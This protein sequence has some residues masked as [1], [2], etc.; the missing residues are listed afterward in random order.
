MASGGAMESS[1][2]SASPSSSPPSTP[3]DP[4]DEAAPRLKNAWS[5]IVRGSSTP[6]RSKAEPSPCNPQP[7]EQNERLHPHL[8]SPDTPSRVSDSTIKENP[9]SDATAAVVKASPISSSDGFC[10]PRAEKNQVAC[11]VPS[12]MPIASPDK[13]ISESA[14]LESKPTQQSPLKSPKPAWG[15]LASNA[16]SKP[17]PE[18]VMGAVAWPAL[19]EARNTKASEPSKAVATQKAVSK[20]SPLSGD[21]HQLQAPPLLNREVGGTHQKMSTMMN[22]KSFTQV[23]VNGNNLPEPILTDTAFSSKGVHA[24]DADQLKRSGGKEARAAAAASEVHHR[25]NAASQVSSHDSTRSLMWDQGRGNHSFPAYGRGYANARESNVPAHHQRGGHRNLPQPF[26]PFVTPN[27]G[28]VHPGGFQNVPGSMY[29]IPAPSSEPILGATYFVPPAVQGVLMHG[30]DPITL[31]GLVVKQIEYYFSVENLCRDIY[32]RSKMDERGFVPVSVI[33][34]FNRVRMITQN[35]F[36]IIEALRMSNVVEGQGDKVRKKGDWANWL[37]P[38][39]L[40]SAG[41]SSP[42]GE[43][44]QINKFSRSSQKAEGADYQSNG[45]G[46]SKVASQ[47]KAKKSESHV[48]S[49]MNVQSVVEDPPQHE[50]CSC[51]DGRVGD[52]SVDEVVESKHF[53]QSCSVES[54]GSIE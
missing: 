14:S 8:L 30:P 24:I 18:P 41:F 52:S 15:K 29:Y 2:A 31:Q 21:R 1:I 32:L 33:A 54:G 51:D 7:E 16:G 49:K 53:T 40:Q 6:A 45:V 46:P 12:E 11:D 25:G 20:S 23:M 19:S 44:D 37:L 47:V 50:V 27:P 9:P 34:N 13:L 22:Q 38:A 4:I 28:F 36:L 48:V 17:E 10:L 26:G 3:P 43:G 35:P 42:V 5:Q 39:S